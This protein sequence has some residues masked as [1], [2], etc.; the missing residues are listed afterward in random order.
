MTSSQHDENKHRSST[1]TANVSETTMPKN[2]T[3]SGTKKRVKVT[4]SGKLMHAGSG[5]RHNLESKPTSRTR[6]LDGSKEIA[7]VDVPRMRKLLGI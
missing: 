2:K 7:K 4:G 6:R 3:H 5:K 1:T